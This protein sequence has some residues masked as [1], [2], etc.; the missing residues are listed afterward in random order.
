MSLSK[1]GRPQIPPIA[2]DMAGACAA[3]LMSEGAIRNAMCRRDDPLPSY[4]LG[5]SRR[6]PVR[7]LEAWAARQVPSQPA[8][9]PM[10]RAN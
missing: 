2:L 1:Q 10:R 3:L 7:E 6:F 5:T 9:L 4:K 8:P